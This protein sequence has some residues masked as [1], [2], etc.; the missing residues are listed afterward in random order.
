MR[1]SRWVP[2]RS[3]EC[4]GRDDAGLL[5][6]RPIAHMW[7]AVL[8]TYRRADQEHVRIFDFRF[9]TLPRRQLAFGLTFVVAHLRP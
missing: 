7:T 8:I 5:W 9:M 3:V 2:P 4:Q 6:H 1:A